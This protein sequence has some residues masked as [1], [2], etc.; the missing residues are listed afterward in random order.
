MTP[1][2]VQTCFAEEIEI[3]QQYRKK[4][5]PEDRLYP[6]WFREMFESRPGQGG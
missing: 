4:Y 3:F 5:D 1:H 2:Q 6:Q